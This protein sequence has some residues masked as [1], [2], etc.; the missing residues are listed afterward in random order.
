LSQNFLK[1]LLPLT[2]NLIDLEL[3]NYSHDTI[4]NLSDFKNLEK[5]SLLKCI[6][7][8][9]YFFDDLTQLTNLRY[10][11]FYGSKISLYNIDSL[12]KL[13]YFNVSEA[14]FNYGN[15]KSTLIGL[16]N[17]KYLDITNGYV[18][19]FKLN[20]SNLETLFMEKNFCL[21]NITEEELNSILC[22]TLTTLC[23]SNCNS[24]PDSFPSY[25]SKMVHLRYLDLS[26]TTLPPNSTKMFNNL[27]ELRYLNLNSSR[28]PEGLF[29]ELVLNTEI[30]FLGLRETNITEE[31][32]AILLESLPDLNA[33]DISKTSYIT[34]S[35]FPLLWRK[36][37]D[38]FT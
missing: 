29:K 35:I 22:K 4:P 9:N 36:K 17:L 15:I 23:L 37:K 3:G 33:L 30:R 6:R 32:L 11:N 24:M 34:Q 28:M 2:P 19:N 7:L 21:Q 26:K 5:L 31:D 18:P 14:N 27:V 8:G 38:C 25:I 13:E 1:Q 16:T 10:L 12:T 20:T